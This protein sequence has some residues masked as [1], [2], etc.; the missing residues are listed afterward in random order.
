MIEIR[1]SLTTALE[2]TQA[3]T[4]WVSSLLQKKGKTS[5]YSRTSSTPTIHD[6][7]HIHNKNTDL[8]TT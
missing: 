7:Q 5:D 4:I 6:L 2:S 1:K 3:N 8:L